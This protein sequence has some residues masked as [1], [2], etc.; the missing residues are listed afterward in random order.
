MR[1]EPPSSHWRQRKLPKTYAVGPIRPVDTRYGVPPARSDMGLRNTVLLDRGY[2]PI[3]E[4]YNYT[5]KSVDELNKHLGLYTDSE[6]ER[7]R[8]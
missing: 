8:K 7:L 5:T 2:D 6:A 1:L 3:T 4:G